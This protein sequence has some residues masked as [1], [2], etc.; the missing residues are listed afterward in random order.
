MSEPPRKTSAQAN[1]FVHPSI[2]VVATFPVVYPFLLTSP[3][4]LDIKAVGNLQTKSSLPNR[5]EQG[6]LATHLNLQEFSLEYGATELVTVDHQRDYIL[7]YE[8]E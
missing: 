1:S 3:F 4:V 6:Y 5:G 8:M 2:L 7:L